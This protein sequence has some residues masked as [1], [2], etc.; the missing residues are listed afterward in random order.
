LTL[1]GAFERI[2]A[3]IGMQ[4][5]GDEYFER[6]TL[7]LSRNDAERFADVYGIADVEEALQIGARETGNFALVKAGSA[8]LPLEQYAPLRPS[9]RAAYTGKAPVTTIDARKVAE[10]F[11]QGWT[12]I[13]KDASLFSARMQRFCNALQAETG[14]FVQ[15]NV[16]LTPPSAQGFDVH[17]DTHGTLIIQIEGSKTWRVYKP[18]VDLPLE[19]Q[20]FSSAAH[21]GKIA[22]DREVV[23]QPG[24]TLYI[25]HGFAHEA[26]SNASRTLHVTFAML[27]LRVADLLERMLALG[28]TLD[29][30]LRRSLPP[31]W[32]RDDA[33]A[34]R[35][36]ASIRPNIDAA[37]APSRIGAAGDRLLLEFYGATRIDAQGA[38]DRVAAT[39]TVA[40]SD[41]LRMRTDVP[42]VVGERADTV[43]LLIPGRSLVL[44]TPCL[45]ALR[46]LEEGPARVN[47]LPGLADVN[48]LWLARALLTYGVVEIV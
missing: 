35:L 27:P 9:M 40:L 5:F 15:P 2:F 14:W 4:R 17:Y 11:G 26:A 16:Y 31:G 36:L 28:A 20:P 47:E 13:V 38:F 24:D 33:L 30:E 21:Q 42:Y 3:P 7:H 12:L 23:M 8:E 10:F 37:F 18:L 22:L 39:A 34:Q 25:P 46:R 43:T 19:S 45:P 48:Q 41:V 32:H 6:S 44:P 1:P 29:V